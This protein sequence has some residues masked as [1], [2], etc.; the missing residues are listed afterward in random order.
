MRGSRLSAPARG[1][2]LAAAVAVALG[3]ALVAR[4]L[5]AQPPAASPTPIV[6]GGSPLLNQPAPDISGRDLSGRTINLAQYR[7]RPV[8]VNFWASWCIP[9][10]TEFPLFRQARAM[11]ADKG[12]EII[13]VIYQDTPDAAAEFMRSQGAQWPAVVD[14]GTAA[15]AYT[16]LAPPVSFY[17]DRGGVVRAVSYGPPPED[18]F[19]KQLSLIL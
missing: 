19:D 15:R 16:V 17:V 4:Q 3:G 11:H 8:I 6:V 9:C 2:L 10:R 1:L 14:S 18:V 5:A 12:L 13:G 7:G